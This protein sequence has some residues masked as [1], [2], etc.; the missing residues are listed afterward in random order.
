M[1][2][3]G[4]SSSTGVWLRQGL[5]H[6][7]AVGCGRYVAW[8]PDGRLIAVP[9]GTGRV[10]IRDVEGDVE[11]A[12]L[13]ATGDRS[14]VN[15]VSWSPDGLRLAGACG[16]D[17]VRIW[18]LD[19]PRHSVHLTEHTGWVGQVAWAHAGH[20]LASGAQDHTARIW[21]AR[22]GLLL[23]T[24]QAHRDYVNCLAW[25]PDDR[26]LATGSAD[27][28]VRA[29][30]ADT[31]AGP[32]FQWT[33]DDIVNCL[34][35]SADGDVLVAGTTG[36]SLRGVVR[37]D[38]GAEPA[39]VIEGHTDSIW[40]TGVSADGRLVA[41]V[42][43]DGTI[44]LWHADRWTSVATLRL[45]DDDA[46]DVVQRGV[47]LDGA[48]AA[49]IA[50]GAA[51]AFHPTLPRL[52]VWTAHSGLSIWEYDLDQLLGQPA[53]VE[54]VRYMTAKVVLVGDSGV[55][56]TGLGWRLAHDEFR[57]HASTHGQQFWVV[58]DVRT[59][60]ADGTDCEA[61]L[62][63]LAGQHVYR[64][65]HAIF[66]DN[67]DLALVLFDPTNRQE[68][69]KGVEF[70]LQ[71][72]SGGGSLPPTVLVGARD[73]RGTSALPSSDLQQFCQSRGISGGYVSTS[74]ATGAGVGELMELLRG[75]I[76]WERMTTTVTT[77]TF[78]RIKEY[79]LALKER[80]DRSEV[81]VRPPELREQL[82]ATDAG[83]RFTDD[84][85]MTA[86]GHLENHGYVSVLRTSAGAEAILLAPELLVDLAS[87][88]FLQADKHPQ[89][90]GAMSE[91]S[92]LAGEYRF[93]E[94]E[95]LAPDEKQVLVD[96]AVARFLE[97][98]LCF[99]ETLG[100]ET[101]LIFPGLIKQKRPLYDAVETV[102]D[103]TYVVRG[104]VEN[105]YA[106]LVVLLGHT[107][108]FTRVN[109]WQNQ[110]QFEMG[111]GEI[112]GLRLLQERE[113][114]IELVLH[115][116][117][118]VPPYGRN[119][120]QGLLEG[121][122]YE[123]RDVT[124]TP[125]PPVAC[126]N[127]HRQDRTV[128]IGALRDGLRTMFCSR[129][130]ERVALPDL[131]GPVALGEE[132]RRLVGTDRAAA[133][134][135]GAYE[136]RLVRVKSFRADRAVPR[137]YVSHLPED[138]E[139]AAQLARDLRDAGVLVVEEAGDVQ[140]DDFVLAVVTRA[141]ARA[142]ARLGADAA[143]IRARRRTRPGRSPR[144]APLL[145][146]GAA[147]GSLPDELR[148][149]VPGEFQDDVWYDRYVVALF[150]LVLTLYA[151][152]FDHPAFGGLRADMQL[153]ALR[154]RVAVLQSPSR[155]QPADVYLSYSWSEESDAL[156]DELDAA[157]QERG[158]VMV[159]DRRDAGYKASIGRF[160]E[161]I[162]Q[163]KCVILVISDAYLKSQSCLFELLQVARHG[164]FRERVF[165]VVLPDARI[166][167]P[168]DRVAYV[169]YWEEQ[170]AELDEALKSVSAAN[171][172][173]FREDMDLYTE[174][175]AQLPGLADILRDMN[176]LTVDLHRDAAFSEVHAAVMSRINLRW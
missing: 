142:F 17:G 167:R 11:I 76:Q 58:D 40:D 70:W 50:W 85:M 173:G 88:I 126:G 75:Q 79:V 21:D 120:F 116:S 140:E 5:G 32:E 112:C 54:S 10:S 130:G 39:L 156:A 172:Q 99:R 105:V 132:D 129:C 136:T 12:E 45:P 100:A 144:V 33:H 19:K 74:A 20:R 7:S 160:M 38:S 149:L 43:A 154:S 166:H 80:P 95:T 101:L 35:W 117:D 3:Y 51:L 6:P 159:R 1:A 133:R 72:L 121:F 141:Y 27:Q 102:D 111:S 66:L 97:H 127:G 113:G 158:L 128:V 96:A 64:P 44:R 25:S 34:A 152:P 30:N 22:T 110:A 98:N 60:R 63:D 115:Y 161:R 71:Q 52:A 78:K 170:I 157:F 47:D 83:W 153:E 92:L 56:K 138:A 107:R 146:T 81:L 15:R 155:E 147:E 137:C 31:G 2:E 104:R 165:P 82:Q 176:A 41:T 8:S 134:L 37:P 122:L 62:W 118:A 73:D 13:W 65:V 24:I 135:R 67:V 123:R 163:G 91:A 103:M 61:V 89:E 162:G 18:D 119:A 84:E 169:R 42:S 86:V 57:E 28:R 131:D 124:V 26:T 46:D 150:D 175:R 48:E 125:F 68:P 49:Y 171:L 90:L 106:A 168:Q 36:G 29:W 109:Y 14:F 93:P 53:P 108:R 143:L 55:G 151:I 16:H 145:R 94:L 87:S 4:E 77:V 174:I 23:R 9:S 139:W 69:L 59:Q 114:E 148:G 164:D